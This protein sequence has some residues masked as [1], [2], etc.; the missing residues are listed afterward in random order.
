MNPAQITAVECSDQPIYALS[1]INQWLFPKF[2][3]LG[4]LHKALL[5]THGNLI[6][7]SGLDELLGDRQ[8][9]TIG[10]QTA[11]LDVNHI[12]K[13]R[14][15]IQLPLVAIYSSLKKAHEKWNQKVHYLNGQLKFQKK[16]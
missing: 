7:G 12:H 13:G 4:G 6:G 2:A 11:A 9:E 16:I 15:A 8:I 3:L 5:T 14:Y 10:L 1:K